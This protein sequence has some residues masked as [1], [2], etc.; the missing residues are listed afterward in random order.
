MMHMAG[1]LSSLDALFFIK[2]IIYIFN[3]REHCNYANIDSRV[4]E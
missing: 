2:T 4:Y 3:R 1:K